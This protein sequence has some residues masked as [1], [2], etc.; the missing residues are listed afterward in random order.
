MISQLEYAPHPLAKI[1]PPMSA[2]EL[3]ELADDIGK[4]RFERSDPSVRGPN[5]R[6][7]ASRERVRDV[8][9][10]ADVSA[11]GRSQTVRPQGSLARAC[12]AI[13]LWNF[14]RANRYEFE[15]SSVNICTLIPILPWYPLKFLL[16][17]AK[18]LEVEE[19]RP[20]KM[21]QMPSKK[22]PK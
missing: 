4:K 1:F 7:C 12:V 2:E 21:T 9:R 5:S 20:L 8:R 17:V 19:N 13:A 15:T 16:R 10:A 3:R 14:G 6:W 22:N 18:I 11:M